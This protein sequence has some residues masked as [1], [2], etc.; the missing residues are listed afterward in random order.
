MNDERFSP[1]VSHDPGA[2]TVAP[3]GK[4]ASAGIGT[5]PAESAAAGVP[6][7]SALVN[8][9]AINA[10]IKPEYV[11]FVGHPQE[12]ELVVNQNQLEAREV[13]VLQEIEPPVS[14][15][16]GSIMNR[17]DILVR[18]F[19]FKPS[20]T[21]TMHFRPGS[22]YE[23]YLHPRGYGGKWRPAGRTK[24]PVAKPG[25]G[26]A[27]PVTTQAKPGPAEAKS[28]K[29]QTKIKTR[30]GIARVGPIRYLTDK[31][32]VSI[33]KGSA[34]KLVALMHDLP[35][36]QEMAEVALAGQAKRGWYAGSAR[37][38]VDVFGHDAPRF[39]A[40]LAA[41]SPRQA[42]EKNLGMALR[43]WK[44]WNNAD[45]PTDPEG[46]KK[47]CNA[48]IRQDELEEG[49]T[50][51]A[52][53]NN[54]TLALSHPHPEDEESFWLSGPKV[55][56]FR[57]NLMDQVHEVTNDGWMAVY[58]GVPQK[59]FEG[60]KTKTGPGK[61]PGYLSMAVRTRQTAEYLTK[62]TGEEWT[63]AEVQET[64]WTYTKALFE[65]T[66]KLSRTKQY[67][68]ITAKE[69]VEKGLLSDDDI[70]SVPDFASAFVKQ[71]YATQLEQA[72]YGEQLGGLRKRSAEAAVGGDGGA[73]GVSE[74]PSGKG[75]AGGAGV[76]KGG[77]HLKRLARRLDVLRAKR[78]ADKAAG[79]DV[80]P[81][82][83]RQIL[84]AMKLLALNSGTSMGVRKSWLRRHRG[85]P[86]L[87]PS[88]HS[89]A[90]RWNL[91][92]NE[93]KRI[94]RF[95]A[96]KQT[97]AEFHALSEMA[98]A[99]IS[100]ARKE[101]HLV[102]KDDR[103][104]ESELKAGFVGA[105][106]SEIKS[107]PPGAVALNPFRSE[108]QRR[109]M[110]ARHP[111]IAKRWAAENPESAKGNLPEHVSNCS[112]L[113]AMSPSPMIGGYAQ[114]AKQK[115]VSM[116][117][118]AENRT[119]VRQQLVARKMIHPGSKYDE[120]KH[121]RLHG[122]WALKF[123]GGGGG[124]PVMPHNP[125]VQPKKPVPVV[126]PPKPAKESKPLPLGED[127]RKARHLARQVF[128]A[129]GFTYHPIMEKSPTEGFVVSAYK[130]HELVIKPEKFR[131]MGRNQLA[132]VIRKHIRSAKDTFTSDEKAH[133]GGFWDVTDGTMFLDV[134]QLFDDKDK[135][136][137]QGRK[138][139]ERSIFDLGKKD[140]I[141][142]NRDGKRPLRFIFPRDATPE[143]MAEALLELAK[144]GGDDDDE[145][146]AENRSP[147][148]GQKP[149]DVSQF[150]LAQLAAGTRVEKEHT[151]DPQL[152]RQ[153]AMDHLAEDPRYYSKLSRCGL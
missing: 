74:T 19:T 93:I 20:S 63:P 92:P 151:S 38:I 100:D 44:N 137:D 54:A 133:L 78:K 84:I 18:N 21:K 73:G 108:A 80:E 71:E 5:S 118:D 143:Q 116:N 123:G 126:K 23:E 68:G 128:E 4:P 33:Q 89:M 57:K 50:M 147:I 11:V 134:V 81:V 34:K 79:K 35:S 53:L 153:I 152:A 129:K 66:E 26:G 60:T 142:C 146:E 32:Y 99:A 141:S 52:F 36:V 104:V 76:G 102:S 139:N 97:S 56:S 49:T 2:Q 3:T 88:E 9:L 28:P 48:S 72:G 16:K 94:K 51:S 87:S 67:A 41:F 96:G 140:V 145:E 58:A 7:R 37:A 64:V 111:K 138:L 29:K 98:Q 122:K 40:V 22:K 103:W 112:Q 109:F 65:K 12:R 90:E 83:N 150:D 25:S 8:R 121:P 124:A 17:H 127:R 59:R 1:V 132:N 75:A 13:E 45:R 31:E 119:P 70:R 95:L 110:F 69:V 117:C 14:P 113:A 42:V 105:S 30:E 107:D 39:V 115:K 149:H 61:R 55:D 15:S 43:V 10:R 136:L 62:V 120:A 130:K 101:G 85:G 106:K 86:P 114:G 77:T 6:F 125:L 46:I 91:E 135:A 24:A 148:P 131:S 82:G 27:K 47:V 144:R